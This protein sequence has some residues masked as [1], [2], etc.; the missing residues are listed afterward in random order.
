M[1]PLGRWYYRTTRH[2]IVANILLPPLVFL[3]L[4]RVPFDTPRTWQRERRAVY[5]TD[6]TLIASYG[7]LGLLLGFGEVAA[8]HL[9]VI[10]MASIIGVWLFSVQHR[11]EAVQWVRQDNWDAVSASLRSSTYLRLPAI[12]QWFTGNIGFH[13]VHHIQPGIPNYRLQDCHDSMQAFRDVPTLSILD[14]LR[15]VN[16][17]LW[18]ETRGRMVTFREA[19]SVVIGSRC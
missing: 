9:P 10:V 8:V 11:G 14:G 15:S 5:L 7:G 13:H 16:S 4:Y 3:G 12:L 17:V 18:D 1:A 6:V 2:P 19:E